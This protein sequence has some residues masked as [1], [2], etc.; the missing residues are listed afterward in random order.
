MSKQ[1]KWI[2]Q[3]DKCSQ[4]VIANINFTNTNSTKRLTISRLLIVVVIFCFRVHRLYCLISNVM[5]MNFLL[6]VEFIENKLGN[7]LF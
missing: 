7:F 3:C 6:P 2:S 1:Y 5:I 4:C